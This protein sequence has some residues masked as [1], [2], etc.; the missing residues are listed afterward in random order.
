MNNM[1]AIVHKFRRSM[2]TL[3]EDDEFFV[4]KK[5]LNALNTYFSH[6]LLYL[7]RLESVIKNIN[8]MI[9]DLNRCLMSFFENDINL[10][11]VQHISHILN[12]F[13]DVRE[14]MTNHIVN[15]K[16]VTNETLEKIKKIQNLCLKKKELG[17]SIEHYEK[18]IKKLQL[19]NAPNQK[20]LEKIIRNESKLNGVKT[21]YLKYNEYIKKGFDIVLENKTNKVLLDA[22]KDLELLLCYFSLMNSVSVKLKDPLK[23]MY[24]N[25]QREKLPIDDNFF[26]ECQ[27]R[28]NYFYEMEKNMNNYNPHNRYHMHNPKF[29]YNNY[30]HH[31]NK[32]NKYDPPSRYRTYDNI[33]NIY[34]EYDRRNINN[35]NNNYMLG[36]YNRYSERNHYREVY[37]HNES[38]KEDNFFTSSLNTLTKTLSAYNLN[39]K[40]ERV[41]KTNDLN[42]SGN[43]AGRSSS[44]STPLP[45][46]KNIK[47]KIYKKTLNQDLFVE[48]D[49]KKDNSFLKIKNILGVSNKPKEEEKET[50]PP[51]PTPPAFPQ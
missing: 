35:N 18:K 42:S 6:S 23:D 16:S 1:K 46:I 45:F 11:I 44:S 31:M 9:S 14:Q 7:E 26:L 25:T 37:N 19:V 24:L 17:A 47:N 12:T 49:D 30:E 2:D 41:N 48:S 21:D 34:N 27:D 43:S 32:Y 20:H 5:Q 22:R 15:A 33:P 50:S 13:T 40:S 51:V 29:E 3:K 36:D 39:S 4:E 38:I 28:M 10:G 8:I